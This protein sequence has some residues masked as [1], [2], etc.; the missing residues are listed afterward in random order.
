MPIK[1]R[2]A[3]ASG[4]VAAVLVALGVVTLQWRVS[5]GI[6]ATMRDSLRATGRRVSSD[7]RA[8][9]LRLDL[10]KVMVATG[11]SEFVQIA[12]RTGQVLYTTERAGRGLLVPKAQF[13]GG[14]LNSFVSTEEGSRHLLLFVQASGLPGGE[15][16]VVGTTEDE[17]SHALSEIWLVGGLGGPIIIGLTV[18]G[19]FLLASAALRP[20]GRLGASAGSLSSSALDQRLVVPH[21][22]DELASLATTLNCFLD[23]LQAVV[24]GQNW[25]IQAASHELKTPLA[26][27]SAQLQ[28]AQLYSSDPVSLQKAHQSAQAAVDQLAK[29]STDLLLLARGQAGALVLEL[30]DIDLEDVAADALVS[31]SARNTN[32]KLGFVL[33]CPERVYCYADPVRVR[34]V[35]DNLLENCIRY[36]NSGLVTL[37]IYAEQD[38]VAIVVRDRG[39]GFPEGL[40]ASAFESFRAGSLS[41]SRETGG[42]GLGLTIVKLLVELQKGTVSVANSIDGGA[43]VS[44]RLPRPRDHSVTK[45]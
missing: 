8:G 16:I 43:I 12:T 5:E 24:E 35:F 33:D 22:K 20:V 31:A 36:A 9:R 23:R 38:W 32:P 44:I 11:D 18:L 1:W 10:Q 27:I 13:A 45:S 30:C 40:L 37:S 34:Q 39:I 29:L 7:L 4:I 6:Q 41:R 26:T 15:R 19:A 21:T 2:L 3:L 14:T 25:F 42:A 28:I 17:L